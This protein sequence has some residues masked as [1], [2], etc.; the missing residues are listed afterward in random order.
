ME[1]CNFTGASAFF[2]ISRGWVFTKKAGK[3]IFEK[4][5]HPSSS[6]EPEIVCNQLIV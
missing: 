3:V 2:T 1:K 6:N 4:K 5:D